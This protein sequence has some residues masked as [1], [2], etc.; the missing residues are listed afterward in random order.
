MPRPIV[1]DA[2]ANF[3]SYLHS[4]YTV[5]LMTPGVWPLQLKVS[6]PLSVTAEF[7]NRSPLKLKV[8]RLWYDYFQ[9]KWNV[10]QKC[11]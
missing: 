10:R 8:H 9:S 3:L 5:R 6:D 2:D 4:Q 7:T 1:P 11:P